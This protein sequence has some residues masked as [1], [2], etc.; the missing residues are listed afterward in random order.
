MYILVV[1]DDSIQANLICSQLNRAF[2]D[3]R[4][5]RIE[6]EHEFRSHLVDIPQDP[7]DVIVLDIML[8]WTDPAPD[9]PL[10]P[11]DVE[12]EGPNRAGFRCKEILA[13]DVITKNI[14][15]ILYTVLEREDIAHE[16]ARLL[17]GDINYVRKDDEF[18]SLIREIR[19]LT[20]LT[21]R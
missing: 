1:E 7:P 21:A 9:M 16:F 14:P 5:R 19:R 18:E 8:R 12:A 4:I 3:C 11:E 2:P 17:V 15:V 20:A 6:T 13:R 10:W